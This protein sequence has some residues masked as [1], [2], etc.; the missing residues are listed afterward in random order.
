MRKRLSNARGPIIQSLAAAKSA[1]DATLASERR[2]ARRNCSLLAEASDTLKTE[3]K[4]LAASALENNN[5]NFLQLANS[6]LRNPESSR[7]RAG[8][9]RNRRL[10]TWSTRSRN[11]WLE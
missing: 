5:A 10:R 1:L 4:A 2:S 3:F 6:V 9:R 8:A 11:R 7:R